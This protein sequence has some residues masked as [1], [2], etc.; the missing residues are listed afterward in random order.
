MDPASLGTVPINT[1]PFRVIYTSPVYVPSSTHLLF[2]L[3]LP[4]PILFI[5]GH[6][7]RC[8]ESFQNAVVPCFACLLFLGCGK[9][10]E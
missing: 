5:A 4:F 3:F 1:S 10:S 8:A 9:C 6:Q 2:F 7:I